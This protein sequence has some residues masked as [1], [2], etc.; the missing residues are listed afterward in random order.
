MVQIPET[1]SQI[2]FNK[3]DIDSETGEES[4]PK[5]DLGATANNIYITLETDNGQKYITLDNF[6][7][8]L[9]NYFTDGDFLTYNADEPQSYNVKL[10][11][12]NLV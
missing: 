10:W 1:I 11:Y 8:Y 9:Y 4:N 6:A 7:K 12:E 2:E 3:P 5:V